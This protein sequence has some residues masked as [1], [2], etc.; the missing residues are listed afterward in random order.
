MPF[1]KDLYANKGGVAARICGHLSFRKPGV[2]HLRVADV[3]S[4]LC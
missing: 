3:P 4:S 2:N 1:T